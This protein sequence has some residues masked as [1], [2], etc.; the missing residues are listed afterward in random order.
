MVKT[1]DLKGAEINQET[2]TGTKSRKKRVLKPEKDIRVIDV[3]GKTA[4][5][6]V[7][8]TIGNRNVIEF[9]GVFYGAK[10]GFE[11]SNWHDSDQRN[12]PDLIAGNTEKEIRRKILDLAELEKRAQIKP[13]LLETIG[14]Y[15]VIEFDGVYYGVQQGIEISNWH[16]SDQ[17]N[18]PDLIVG[19]TEKEIRRK[20][21]KKLS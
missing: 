4:E 15:N 12:H 13:E 5:P 10:H 3:V 17:R 21:L 6:E 7:L 19:N 11:V 16:D 14:H 20:I 1:S 8:Q 9:D 2:T 18:H